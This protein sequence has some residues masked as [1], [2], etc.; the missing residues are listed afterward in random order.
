MATVET[1]S[2]IVDQ[3]GE[4]AGEVWHTLLEH[5]QLTMTQLTKR[6]DAPRDRVMQA[7]GWLAREE[8]ICIDEQAR[9]KVISLT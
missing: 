1:T 5:G 7:V 3:I 6:V 8:K 9:R 4:T 2:L